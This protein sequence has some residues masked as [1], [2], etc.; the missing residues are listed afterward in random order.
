MSTGRS[1]SALVSVTRSSGSMYRYWSGS[2]AI[3]QAKADLIL[4][5]IV[6]FNAQENR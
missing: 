4:K 1:N 2:T 3:R 5:W 6:N